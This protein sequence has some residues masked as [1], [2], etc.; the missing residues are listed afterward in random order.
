MSLR[1]KYPYSELFW[2]AF[3]RIRTE[4]RV[5]PRISPYSVRIGEFADQNNSEYGHYSP[6]VYVYCELSEMK[7]QEK[8][9]VTVMAK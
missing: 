3:S 2:S 1:K 5:I 4:Y 8:K 9:K 6:N 7:Q